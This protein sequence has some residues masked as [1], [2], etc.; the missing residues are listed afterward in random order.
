[1]QQLQRTHGL[2]SGLYKKVK[3]MKKIFFLCLPVAFVQAASYKPP[4]DIYMPVTHYESSY[5]FITGNTV[6]AYCNHVLDNQRSFNPS[7]VKLGDT[8]FT[9]VDYLDYFFT[10]FHPQI[11][12]SI[13]FSNAQFL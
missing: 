2:C 12:T 1:M 9:M 13:Y 3:L 5:P 10:V 7:D 11:K 6:R 4:K 8:I